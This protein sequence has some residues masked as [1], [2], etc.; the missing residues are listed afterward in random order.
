MGTLRVQAEVDFW[1]ATPTA[2]LNTDSD[3]SD[4]DKK[5]C[6]SLIHSQI[7]TQT[8]SF[9]GL[10][11]VWEAD[12]LKC[13]SVSVRSLAL[14]GQLLRSQISWPICGS[15]GTLFILIQI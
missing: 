2:W 13:F 12:Y 6:Q 9:L 7:Q 4:S 15:A 10:E 8:Y 1:K 14:K 11:E 3:Q 5:H